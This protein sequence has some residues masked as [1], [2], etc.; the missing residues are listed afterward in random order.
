[1]LETRDYEAILAVLERSGRAVTLDGFAESV[2]EGMQRELGYGGCIVMIAELTPDGPVATSGA[3]RG[4][5]DRMEEYFERWKPA[6]PFEH[7]AAR[8]LFARHGL[9]RLHDFYE[10]LDR[11]QRDFC[12]DFLAPDSIRDQISA[13]IDTGLARQGFLTLCDPEG[14]LFGQADKARMAVLRPHLANQLR[15]LIAT[16][17]DVAFGADRGF[18]T[19]RLTARQREVATL[20][21]RGLSNAEIG[22]SLAISESTV[23]KHLVGAYERLGVSSRAQLA[24]RRSRLDLDEAGGRD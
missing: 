24:A 17:A 8:A 6:E 20:A 16:G 1:M 7:P 3:M 4:A 18:D 15:A 21:S 11:P 5:P 2:L 14:G 10:S 9:A 13:H 23:K 19:D 12:T 22:R